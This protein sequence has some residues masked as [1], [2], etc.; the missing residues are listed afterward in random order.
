[1]TLSGTL[2]AISKELIRNN[3]QFCITGGFAYSV[4]AEPRTTVDIDIV[5]LTATPKEEI[6][7]SLETVFPSVYENT[8]DFTYKLVTMHRYL[9]MKEKSEFVF[10]HL[11]VKPE[12]EDY[13]ETLLSRIMRI[14]F[15]GAE[16]PVISREDLIILKSASS[17]EQDLLDARKLMREADTGYLG[18]WAGRLGIEIYGTE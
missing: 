18:T 3:I 1:M 8:I 14:P 5:T 12:Y 9:L 7:K 10:D 4:Y 16:I 11:S 17:R 2:K 6:N 15:A 13:G